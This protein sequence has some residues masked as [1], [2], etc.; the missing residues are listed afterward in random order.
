MTALDLMRSRYSA[1]VVGDGDHL[2]TS[3]HPDTRPD[4][5]ELDPAIEWLGLL[6]ID[7]V[8]GGPLDAEGKV[9]FRAR[10][11]RDGQPG[12]QAERSLF[13]RHDGAWVYHSGRPGL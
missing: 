8:D 2:R 6:I 11:R 3:W 1:Y 5:I 12:D 10:F 4:E 9:T 13:V 7:T